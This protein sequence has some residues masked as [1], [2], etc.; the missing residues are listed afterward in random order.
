MDKS[1]AQQGSETQQQRR[2][3]SGPRII[4]RFENWLA[5]LA[6]TIQLTEDEQMDAGVRLGQLSEDDQKDAGI[7]Q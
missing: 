7:F 5:R 6:Q 4:H 1:F 3:L 2:I